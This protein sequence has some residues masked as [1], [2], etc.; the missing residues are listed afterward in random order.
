VQWVNPHPELLD[1]LLHWTDLR[2]VWLA[3]ATTHEGYLVPSMR[4]PCSTL[5]IQVEGQRCWYVELDDQE[6]VE[7]AAQIERARSAVA[8]AQ[9][10]IEAQP[11]STPPR[12]PGPE[13]WN[14]GAAQRHHMRLSEDRDL[15]R[16]GGWLVA[17]GVFGMLTGTLIA[18]A[19]LLPGLLAV[20]VGLA[21]ALIGGLTLGLVAHHQ[22]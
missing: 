21:C 9:A 6:P 20:G 14:K 13:D 16:V 12:A 22:G 4:N 1:M 11:A 15:S 2:G 7:V 19:G 8:R 3:G 18:A 10:A 5:A 17:A